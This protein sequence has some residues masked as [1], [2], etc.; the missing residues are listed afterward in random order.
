MIAGSDK[1]TVGPDQ[2]HAP[3]IVMIEIVHHP[4]KLVAQ[5]DRNGIAGPQPMRG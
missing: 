1:G 4:I 2:E 3:L 5:L